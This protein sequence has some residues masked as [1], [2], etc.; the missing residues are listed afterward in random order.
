MERYAPG[1][2]LCHASLEAYVAGKLITTA[3]TAALALYGWPLTREGFLDTLF[4]DV[5]KFKLH[6]LTLGSFGDGT[7]SPFAPQTE[8]N[9]CNQGSHEVRMTR[10]L[11]APWASRAVLIDARTGSYK[12]QGCGAAG[13]NYTGRVLLGASF[14]SAPA[15]APVG[16]VNFSGG[17]DNLLHDGIAAAFAWHNGEEKVPMLLST[18]VDSADAA[19]ML[20]DFRGRGAVG[21]VGLRSKEVDAV[22]RI[23]D[24]V[25]P[26][27][28]LAA[29][30]SGAMALRSPFRKEVINLF[31]SAFQEMKAAVAYLSRVKHCR[32]IVVAWNNRS[33]H[34]G[35]DYFEG[36]TFM[37]KQFKDV[38][39]PEAY[40]W[41]SSLQEVAVDFRGRSVDA[42]IVVGD[43]TACA[44]FYY[45][46]RKLFPEQPIFVTS[47]SSEDRASAIH[48]GPSP[49][50][51]SSADPPPDG[52]L[53]NRTRVVELYQVRG[54]PS[55][56]SFPEDDSLRT[57]YTNWVVDSSRG[58][59]SWKGFL[60]GKFV[61][62]VVSALVLDGRAVTPES[63][64][65]AVYE[66]KVFQLGKIVVGPF[67]KDCVHSRCCN[68]GLDRV[69]VFKAEGLRLVQTDFNAGNW[70]K[71]GAEFD[72]AAGGQSHTA[73]IV[74]VSVCCGFVAGCLL[75]GVI[76]FVWRSKRANTFLVIK[77]SEIEIGS[78]IG[79]GRL[80]A[81]FVGD[82]H[83]TPVAV[84]VIRKQTMSRE[85]LQVIQ[86]EIVFLHKFHHPNLLMF[87]GFCETEAEFLIVSEYMS[88]GSLSEFLKTNKSSLNAF[89]KVS[90]AFDVVKG[91]AYLHSQN[92]PVIH[93]SLTSHSLMIDA[94]A[95]TKV[96]DFWFLNKC[97]GGSGS[98]SRQRSGWMPPEVVA[99]EPITSATDVFAFGIVLWELFEPSALSSSSSNRSAV[100]E[101]GS[102]SSLSSRHFPVIHP[103]TPKEVVDLLNHCWQLQ[104]ERR[105]S[106]F[107]IL[108]NWPT[109]F[110]AIGAFEVPT[111]MSMSPHTASM[112]SPGRPG[113]FSGMPG[114]D[115]KTIGSL[116]MA[117]SDDTVMAVLPP[118]SMGNDHMC[119][120][121]GSVE[122]KYAPSLG[123]GEAL[124][125]L[126]GARLF[127][128]N[129]VNLS[130]T[131]RY[132]HY[133]ASVGDVDGD[134]LGDMVVAA[135]EA[136]K[137]F[138][139][140]GRRGTWPS[141]TADADV[142]IRDYADTWGSLG[143]KTS[144][145]GD[146]NGDGLADLVMG[147]YNRGIRVVFG[148]PRALWPHLIDV[149]DSAAGNKI[150]VVSL[151]PTCSWCQEVAR[152]GEVNG[153]AYD[154]IVVG[155]TLEAS[156][157][158][159]LAITDSTPR[160][161][162]FGAIV[163][164]GDV[165]EDSVDDFVVTSNGCNATL[166]LG[167][168]QVGETPGGA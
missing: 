148:R 87:M 114:D 51:N 145:A 78:L 68:Q 22:L 75:L 88:G 18:V 135:Y 14:S 38:S 66:K 138:V 47:E 35:K 80:G 146:V 95:V 11:Y 49:P 128:A 99:G 149:G 8:Q 94:N 50:F 167:R 110:A 93:G 90:I 53:G 141:S 33:D 130:K 19:A 56:E 84:R 57:D 102:S 59:G 9:W 139:F 97:R 152:A 168:P 36:A 27:V 142:T 132:G 117:T 60:V 158:A 123:G 125:G 82:W 31:P 12:F 129:G 13:N 74:A 136:N 58:V 122:L 83:G 81:V 32:R 89:T 118:P 121:M 92:P 155:G 124:D 163:G 120:D 26:K 106:I 131:S 134:R 109:S 1:M 6:G 65:D 143:W 25:W 64:V 147:T 46:A 164:G 37:A 116:M 71:C 140:F 108:R 10:L 91:I 73:V 63:F 144:A 5:R 29:P 21:I 15:A 100:D 62:A 72:V 85:D 20:A 4:R 42:F 23:K 161:K 137:A 104:P 45:Y 41:R 67:E 55:W 115:E 154:D 162:K 159:S 7:G 103:S 160:G 98:A 127:S 153:D 52:P 34:I 28:P 119:I 40:H 165:D 113:F 77:R 54:V 24:K 156:S 151:C 111:D 3:A 133:V 86:D 2:P 105:P 69:Y 126:D 48:G 30:L 39:P 61:S 17:G 166:F 101:I 70:S 16:N 76:V 157:N 44:Q 107:Q 150:S 112:R 43:T 96:T 79:K